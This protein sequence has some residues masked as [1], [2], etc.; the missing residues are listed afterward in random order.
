[1]IGT[2]DREVSKRGYLLS[3][4]ACCGRRWEDRY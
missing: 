4:G 2:L 1:M 3:V